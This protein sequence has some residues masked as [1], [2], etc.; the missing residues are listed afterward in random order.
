MH[1]RERMIDGGSGGAS[2]AG[3]GL[4]LLYPFIWMTDTVG[5]VVGTFDDW[6]DEQKNALQNQLSNSLAK[7]KSKR[8]NNNIHTHHIVP[9]NDPRG[10]PSFIIINEVYP[11]LGVNDTRNLVQV[12]SR[13]HARLHTNSYYFLVNNVV[14]LAYLSAGDNA[15]KKKCM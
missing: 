7:A 6:I 8:S 1:T 5:S 10:L 9:Q 14:T 15:I 2:V 11:G 13:I 3:G 4:G 12:S